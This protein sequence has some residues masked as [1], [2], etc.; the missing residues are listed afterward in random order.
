MKQSFLQRMALG[1]GETSEQK[2]DAF[3]ALMDYPCHRFGIHRAD[4]R[5]A[6]NK[7]AKFIRYA[8]D[9]IVQIDK[10]ILLVEIKT[11]R[12]AGSKAIMK[13]RQQA[14]PEVKAYAQF[15]P[16]MFAGY[17]VSDK[18]LYM[19]PYAEN[20]WRIKRCPKGEFP[21]NKQV[22]FKIDVESMKSLVVFDFK[23]ARKQ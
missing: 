4:R 23:I 11:V 16:I 7:I 15:H 22:Y 17:D 8:P 14:L 12:K 9:R 19:F 13:V 10:E 20:E 5:F 6:F 18:I 21:D 1:A 2:F 3:C